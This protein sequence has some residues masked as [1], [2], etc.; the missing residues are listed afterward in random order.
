MKEVRIQRGFGG[1]PEDLNGKIAGR[2]IK[3]E[4]IEKVENILKGLTY[5]STIIFLFL[6]MPFGK[7]LK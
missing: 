7:I 4:I 1:V 2:L 6:Y 5:S 3:S